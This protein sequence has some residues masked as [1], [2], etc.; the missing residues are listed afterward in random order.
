[1][2]ALSYLLERLRR[3][4]LPPG[5][6][7]GVMAV[8]SLR[9][10]LSHEVDFLFGQLDEAERRGEL[11]LSAARTEAAERELAAGR[12]RSRMLEEARAEG[13]RVAAQLL[14]A[15]RAGCERRARGMLTEAERES[16]RVL[17]RGRERIPSLVGAVVAKVLDGGL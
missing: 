9:D 15:S 13:E 1:M 5:A 8:P 17:A 6:A 16:E 10:E 11:L 7:A 4:Q 12:T 14:A 3:V 2:S